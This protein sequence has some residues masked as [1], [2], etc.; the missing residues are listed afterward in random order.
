VR[1]L[2]QGIGPNDILVD[3]VIARDN[4]HSVS[5]TPASRAQL[6]EPSDSDLIF[7]FFTSVSYITGHQHSI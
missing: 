5:L 7:F 2:Q 4:I 6:I 1:I 3:I